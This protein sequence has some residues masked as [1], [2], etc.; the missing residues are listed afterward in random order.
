MGT[1]RVVAIASTAIGSEATI[2]TPTSGKTWT[3][4]Q[5]VVQCSATEAT[6][7]LKDNTGGSTVAIV[8]METAAKTFTFDFGP[9]ITSGAAD[10]V[11]TATGAQ[12]GNLSGYAIVV[13]N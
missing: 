13:E 5:L 2:Y 4:K 12:A 8:A 6:V 11:L 3:L 10:R 7:T 9:G 1:P